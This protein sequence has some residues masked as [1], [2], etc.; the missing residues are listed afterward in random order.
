MFFFFF[1]LWY[2]PIYFPFLS[3]ILST[4]VAQTP[5]HLDC[6]GAIV[7]LV[8]DGSTRATSYT[9]RRPLQTQ[10]MRRRRF[11]YQKEKAG[12]RARGKSVRSVWN[13]GDWV[14]K[15]VEDC[16][17]HRV[18]AWMATRLAAQ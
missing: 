9:S 8:V 14:I 3:F 6:T 18:L 16:G 7:I 5:P 10:L 13:Y 12:E 2:S 11:F 4:A 17:V 15:E 1:S